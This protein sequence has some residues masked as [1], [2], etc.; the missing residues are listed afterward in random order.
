[1]PKRFLAAGEDGLGE[2]VFERL[3]VKVSG[4]GVLPHDLAI[5]QRP[6]HG[7]C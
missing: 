2:E 6:E 1:M 5:N 4:D 3:Y 7:T